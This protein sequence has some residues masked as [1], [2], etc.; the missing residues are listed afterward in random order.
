ML[1]VPK[2]RMHPTTNQTILKA[3]NERERTRMTLSDQLVLLRWIQRPE[4]EVALKSPSTIDR[5][6]RFTTR[7]AS[8]QYLLLET[9]FFLATSRWIH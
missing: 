7:P 2:I 3:A 5:E 1:M 9:S 6:A 4:Q 8:R